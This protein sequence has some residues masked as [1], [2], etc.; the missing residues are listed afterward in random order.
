MDNGVGNSA[1]Q[2]NVIINRVIKRIG[3]CI[4]INGFSGNC[5]C[6][7]R[8][9]TRIC[10]VGLFISSVSWQRAAHFLHE[11]TA[12]KKCGCQVV[13]IRFE[14]PKRGIFPANAY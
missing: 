10:F 12:C 7:L 13:L 9:G 8:L 5:F 1:S 11:Y 14:S 2:C 3:S 6:S 4:C